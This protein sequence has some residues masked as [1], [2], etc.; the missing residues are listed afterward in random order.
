MGA[1]VLEIALYAIVSPALEM[2]LYDNNSN[3]NN[4]KS[5]D[6]EE[7]QNNDTVSDIK[8]INGSS[9]QWKE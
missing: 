2:V 3:N 4:N 6:Q 7:E 5:N 8:V 1:I 9:N